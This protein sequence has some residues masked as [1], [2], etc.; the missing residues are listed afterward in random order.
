MIRPKFLLLLCLVLFCTC[1]KEEIVFDDSFWV[2]GSP[3]DY[4]FNTTALD[5]AIQNA[6]ALSDFYALLV[7]RDGHL[8]VEKYYDGHTSSSLFQLRSIT[9]NVTSALT[10]IA[11]EEGL[12]PGVDVRLKEF[13]PGLISGGKDSIRLRDMLNMT[14]G[15]EWDE[16]Q[17]INPITENKIP[18]SVEY[19]LSRDLSSTPSAEFNYNSLSTHVVGDI[20]SKKTGQQLSQYAETKLFEPLNIRTYAWQR[21]P[22]GRNWGGFG[23]QL[24]ARDMAKFGL[25]YLNDGLWDGAQV[26]PEN[27]VQAAVIPQIQVPNSS[28]TGYSYQWWT[29]SGLSSAIYYGSGYGGQGLFIVPDKKLIVIAFQ[30]HNGSANESSQRWNNM[31]AKVFIPIY[32]A[33]L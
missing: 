33:A 25:L 23:L 13:Y 26:V 30:R 4:N 22:E 28:V 12:I 24:R 15:L 16:D 1:K 6:A 31:V 8:I 27:W 9:K 17:E 14:S 29:S 5:S 7:V 19:L 21:D 11:L 20:L 10:G 3:D 18:N 2:A 32:Q